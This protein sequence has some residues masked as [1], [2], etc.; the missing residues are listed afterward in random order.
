MRLGWVKKKRIKNPINFEADKK[1]HFCNF[2][3]FFILRLEPIIDVCFGGTKKI[4]IIFTK[5]KKNTTLFSKRGEIKYKFDFILFKTWNKLLNSIVNLYFNLSAFLDP[6]Y[7][8]LYF[9]KLD[10]YYYC[11]LQFGNFYKHD[12]KVNE[13][14][15][16]SIFNLS[17]QSYSTGSL[18][19][20]WEDKFGYG[21]FPNVSHS[22]FQ[23]AIYWP[24]IANSSFNLSILWF[25]RTEKIH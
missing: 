22:M 8:I 1:D 13:K 9:Q 2:R 7:M 3:F 24:Q 19:L 12:T 11:N 21:N 16:S 6:L 17:E 18:L 14:T 4:P 10:N 5:I 20:Y 15:L 23:F 25:M